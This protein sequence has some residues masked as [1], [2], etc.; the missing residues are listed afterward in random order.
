MSNPEF[1]KQV[2]D[3]LEHLY[4]TAYLGTHPLLPQLVRQTDGSRFTRA[5]KLRGILKEGIE[6]LR[7]QQDLPSTA[8]E[9]RTYYALRYRYTQGMTTAQVESALGISQRQL[10]RDFH[11]GLDD[12]TALLQEVRLDE[13]RIAEGAHPDDALADEPGEIQALRNEMNQ[14][15]LVREPTEVQSLVESAQWMLQPFLGEDSS[16]LQVQLLPSLKPVLVD[17]TLTRQ[18][19][20]QILRL[21]VASG[22][23]TDILLQARAIENHIEICLDRHAHINLQS[24]DWQMAQLLIERQGGTLKAEIQAERE[25][26]SVT[27]PQAEPPRVL[28]I[29]DN[30]AIHEL[31]ERYLTPNFY[32]VVHAHSGAEASQTAVENQPDLI[33]LDVMMPAVD[34]WQVL[35]ELKENPLTARIPIVVC[36]VLKE[37]ELA[38]SLGARAYLKKPVERLELLETLAQLASPTDRAAASPPPAP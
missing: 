12:V 30:P 18:A 19:L 34:G 10:Q 36:S 8:P 38:F 4:D 28:V 35:R 25:R 26:I 9:W 3:A 16:Q 11:K 15:Q 22:Q 33:L 24:S 31:F 7:P 23:H 13:L 20:F 21:M 27:L 1:R 32:N 17:S 5:Q 6:G 2:K 14:W 37:P 29:D